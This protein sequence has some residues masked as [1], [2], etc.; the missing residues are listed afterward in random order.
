MKLTRDILQRIAE[1][2]YNI[3]PGSEIAWLPYGTT[4]LVLKSIEPG[5]IDGEPSPWAELRET[6][7]TF[8]LTTLNF[9]DE[10]A[11]LISVFNPGSQRIYIAE[12]STVGGRPVAFAPEFIRHTS[13]FWSLAD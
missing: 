3:A 11:V 9:P 7:K 8:E 10:E 13:V 5:L 6:T 12:H 2:H 4:E 1:K